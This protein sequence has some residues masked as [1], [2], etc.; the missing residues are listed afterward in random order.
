MTGRRKRSL[1]IAGSAAVI[2][3][4]LFAG[5]SHSMGKKTIPLKMTFSQTD[6]QTADGPCFV[7][8]ADLNAD[9][10]MDLAV[11]NWRDNNISIMLNNGDGS[12]EKRPPH[13]VGLRPYCVT[14]GDFDG[15]GD[16]DL[17]TANYG[18]GSV[19]TLRNTG[20]AEFETAVEYDDDATFSTRCVYPADLNGDGHLDLAA[21]NTRSDNFSIFMN[22]G[23]GLFGEAKNYPIGSAPKSIY[24]GDLDGDGDIDLAVI[25]SGWFTVPFIVFMENDGS[26]AF[27][28]KAEFQV[29]ASAW[30]VIVADLNHDG[31]A[32]LANTN[33]AYQNISVLTGDGEGNFTMDEYYQTPKGPRH[34]CASDLDADGDLDLAVACWHAGQCVL[35]LNQGNGKYKPGGNFKTGKKASCV[36]SSDLNSDGLND[37]VVT[38]VE[39]NTVA[40]LLN[41]SGQ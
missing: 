20:T 38:H 34:L 3:G 35:L 12:F 27:S 4:L 1:V 40:V 10:H 17:V 21:V 33:Y 22:N 25:I 23:E 6:Y 39:S 41:T 32:D 5:T 9:G 7:S 13:R 36:A 2:L 28:R 26:G 24:P 30:T 19:S 8:A 11:A 31:H 29:E 18:S 15:D 37:L 16:L 14:T